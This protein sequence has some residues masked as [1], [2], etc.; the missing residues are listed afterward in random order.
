MGRLRQFIVEYVGNLQTGHPAPV[1]DRRKN[2]Y[3]RELI[4]WI[5]R[6][7]EARGFPTAK[8][9]ELVSDLRHAL[10]DGHPLQGMSAHD[11]TGEGTPEWVPE[12]KGL[13]RDAPS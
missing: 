8:K 2:R 1:P 5:E 9:R 10:R 12:G 13:S 6:Q 11:G 7:M 3:A 4:D